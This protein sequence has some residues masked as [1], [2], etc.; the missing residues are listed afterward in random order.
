[1]TKSEIQAIRALHSKEGRAE[2]G[3]FICEGEKLVDEIHRSPLR[4]GQLY[5]TE[6]NIGAEQISQN[7]MSRISALKTPTNLFATVHIPHHAAEKGGLQ[8]L[9]DGVQDPGNMGTIIRIAD[10][11]G[12]RDIHCSSGC[13]DCFNPKVV[14]ATMGAIA[15]VRVHYGNLVGLLQKNGDRLPVYGTFL[16]GDNI[17]Q[18]ELPHSDGAYIIMGSEGRGVSPEVASMVTH[19]LYIPPYPITSLTVESLNVAVATSIICSEFRRR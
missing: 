7:E 2:Q 15:R 8:L 12:I 1:M 19:K 14:Q 4:I 16:E 5:S 3:L 10:W 11:F 18:S 13:A 6:Y 17:Y 9:L